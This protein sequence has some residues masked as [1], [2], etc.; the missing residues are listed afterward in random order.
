[1]PFGLTRE[2]L[3]EVARFGLSSLLILGIK[4]GLTWIMATRVNAYVAYAITHVVIFFGSYLAHLKFTFRAVHSGQRMRD[5]FKS[6]LFIKL[7]DYVLFG[8]IFKASG[9]ELSLSVL[10][11]SI[12][13]TFVRFTQMKKALTR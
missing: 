12:A 6:V 5:F 7:L 4:I 10:L 11:A 3:F 8:V 2:K 13:V 9:D 1:M